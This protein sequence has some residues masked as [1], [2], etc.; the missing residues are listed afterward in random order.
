MPPSPA[1]LDIS[2]LIGAVEDEILHLVVDRDPTTHGMYEMVR[3]HM[4][5]DGSGSSGKRL[6]PLLGLLAFASITGTLERAL[7]G[8]A[9]V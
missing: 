7:P 4:G 5:L 6:R 2:E 1:T 9:A 3:Y 8:V